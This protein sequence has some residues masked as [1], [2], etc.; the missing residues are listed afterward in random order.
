[1]R[2]LFLL[3]CTCLL[4]G[5]PEL[6]L[7]WE[8]NWLAIDGDRLPGPMRIHYLE[9]YCR[10]NSQTTDWVKHTVVGHE[11]KLVSAA[12]DGSRIELSCIL[13]DGVTVQHLI[14]ASDDEVDFLWAVLAEGSMGKEGLA[15]ERE[16][17]FWKGPKGRRRAE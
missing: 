15:D 2:M 14:T 17:E 4:S 12:K 16:A 7:T 13:K 10:A 6:S 3:L 8:K 9:A 11:T 1:M 5:S